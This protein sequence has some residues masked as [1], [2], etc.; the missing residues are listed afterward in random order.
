MPD[1]IQANSTMDDMLQ[2]I[3]VNIDDSNS[4]TVLSVTDE[5]GNQ[6]DITL[7]GVDSTTLGISDL[8][9]M[10]DQD[11]LSTLYNDFNMFKVD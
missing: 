8:G 2:H 10:S 7:K 1:S 3:N 11:I 4:Q 5:L 9:S 6:T